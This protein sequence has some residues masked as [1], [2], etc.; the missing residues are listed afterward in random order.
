[1]GSKDEIDAY[2]SLEEEND[3]NLLNVKPINQETAEISTVENVNS[4]GES[5]VALFNNVGEIELH[6]VNL[7]E[8]Q[9]KQKSVTV[10]GN[11][12]E[13]EEKRE[14]DAGHTIELDLNNQHYSKNIESTSD[15][16]NLDDEVE[17]EDISIN[18]VRRSKRL[19]LDDEDDDDDNVTTASC[20]ENSESIAVEAE[21]RHVIRRLAI[22]DSDSDEEEREIQINRKYVE[23]AENES[24][25]E[26]F[27]QAEGTPLD[28]IA[29][30]PS[31]DKE[32]LGNDDY[33]TQELH[34]KRLAALCDSEDS[35]EEII[36]QRPS[37]TNSKVPPK[38]KNV[39]KNVKK[40]ARE[41]PFGKSMT[42]KQ[43]MKQRQEIQSESQRML[44]ESRVS[45]P[46]HKPKSYSIK[47]F[48]QRRPRFSVLGLNTSNSNS[49]GASAAIKMTNQQLEIV[50]K[51]IEERE[52]EVQE[53][54]KS[55]SESDNDDQGITPP[56]TPPRRT[57]QVAE[58]NEIEASVNKDDECNTEKLMA[59]II[60][61]VLE[62][63]FIQS[64]INVAN[65]HDALTTDNNEIIQED[66]S[67]SK[68][69]NINIINNFD[70]MTA[71]NLSNEEC[72]NQTIQESTNLEINNLSTEKMD[73]EPSLHPDTGSQF[74]AVSDTCFKEQIQ[75][76]ITSPSHTKEMEQDINND[77]NMHEDTVEEHN[78]DS[79]DFDFTIDEDDDDDGNNHEVPK[80]D[81]DDNS[82]KE[83]N[84]E[85]QYLD[86]LLKKYS[87]VDVSDDLTN[88]DRNSTDKK[89]NKQ[90]LLAKFETVK[91]CLSGGP[92]QDIDLEEGITKPNEV[93]RLMER[94][95]QH[96]LTKNVAKN[97]VQLD[98]INLSQGEVHR[99]TVAMSVDPEEE[100]P[101]SEKPGLRL[102]KLRNEL[103]SQ[104]AQRRSE[105]WQQKFQPLCS[106]DENGENC[107]HEEK[108][109]CGADED[110]ILDDE[111]EGELTNSESS[112]DYDECDEEEE[113]KKDRVKSGFVDDE[114][115]ESEVDECDN[116]PEKDKTD[117]EDEEQDE[118][119]EQ[120]EDYN[121]D[122]SYKTRRPLKRII[123]AFT[124]DSD[125][126]DDDNNSQLLLQKDDKRNENKNM[127]NDDDDEIL[128][129]N[130]PLVDKTPNKE[131][132]QK[133]KDLSFLT[134]VQRLTGLQG[135]NSESKFLQEESLVSPLSLP[136][137]PSPLK[138]TNWNIQKQLFSNSC[139]FLDTQTNM[140]EIAKLCSGKFPS[141]TQ[142]ISSQVLQSDI[143][144]SLATQDVLSICSGSFPD[145]TQESQDNSKSH[146][147]DQKDEKTN[148]NVFQ[149]EEKSQEKS[150]VGESVVQEESPL[151]IHSKINN[152]TKY[153][154]DDKLISQ[155]LDE[156]ELESFKKKF[157]SPVA[158][159]SNFT[160]EINEDEV[161][162]V[163]GGG[164]L[165][166]DSS[167]DEDNIQTV[168][169]KSKTRKKRLQKKLAFSDDESNSDSEAEQNEEQGEVID[170]QDDYLDDE[171]GET[172]VV[173][174]D[175]EE[176]EIE[177]DENESRPQK[178]L[179][180]GDFLEKEAELSESDWDSADEDEK[181][182]DILEA[183]QGDAD[184]FD[185]K[186]I[187]ND[188]EKIHM[189]RVLDDDNREI[190]ILQ[191]L[192]LEDGELHGTGRQRQ[193]RWRNV[194][195]TVNDDS[196]Q[197][198]EIETYL[199]DEE[200]EEQWRRARHQR[201]MY[202]RTK[203][204]KRET[205]ENEIME[206]DTNSQVL[207]LGQEVVRKSL[208]NTTLTVEK[209]TVSSSTS[210]IAK[211]SILMN[212]RGS[213]LARNDKFLTRL[214]EFTKTN[215]ASA[216][217][218]SKKIVFQTIDLDAEDANVN[219]IS[220]I[221]NKRK[222]DNK[223]GT[224]TIIKKLR[225][226]S[227]LTPDNKAVKRKKQLFR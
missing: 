143:V 213:F 171:D 74:E 101:V 114:A 121:S 5:C 175:S 183:E 185:E 159:T 192:L 49:L 65:E 154:D 30:L 167:D 45:L 140:E 70:T 200:C 4:S 83:K 9:E 141:S 7:T 197:Q 29:S 56:S 147:D 62:N 218:N 173:D 117:D 78:C 129:P 105:M 164:R 57:N 11:T 84:I 82:V 48:L 51:K 158:A 102:Q 92:N 120:N 40:S 156:E 132:T 12:N 106:K 220:T 155:L 163:V 6:S 162:E 14:C 193:F 18:K 66:A 23:D 72:M 73:S 190:K 133:S 210:E 118:D 174:Y 42:V 26:S 35:D 135:F 38:S 34:R 186:Q 216:I 169:K 112:D 55:E 10:S 19:V 50:T 126:D 219:N 214:A 59:D 128:P 64:E 115:E 149:H 199:D 150:V 177:L 87:T 196:A 184:V 145:G 75:E 96:A 134:P 165:V 211:P 93:V 98:V 39:R 148:D 17:S 33:V 99:E 76:S 41:E 31:G 136:P 176:N 179:R 172:N 137:D 71:S 195:D 36:P 203:Q 151:E 107:D 8:K 60:N 217:K 139:D 103:Q 37:E 3:S 182:L 46:Y 215:N 188:L 89:L 225:L 111:D 113:T 53:F 142:D 21:K 63:C 131:A 157:E 47:E 170:L 43:A 77:T 52:K 227:N 122:T 152:E 144:E 15:N 13:C 58:N 146:S 127:W 208:S 166:S 204:E 187:R 189:R 108:S 181:G 44:R 226:S 27:K 109:D 191:E 212:T 67:N 32:N 95:M 24:T 104:I 198:T 81:C 79:M 1:M 178:R 209:T 130:Q 90:K 119:G 222:A 25:T 180:S 88:S 22:V 2:K 153:L 125:E 116:V 91:P 223:D 202:L 16:N 168:D 61:D 110:N 194:D 80:Q 85:D 207:K 221:S 205:L 68:N 123:K 86:N 20:I 69:L 224:P 206:I 160:F 124:E 28:S 94:F 100:P 54:Y 201:E 138:D 161:D 97:K